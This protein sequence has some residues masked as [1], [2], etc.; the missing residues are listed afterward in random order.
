MN[1]PA[2]TGQENQDPN[3][4]IEKIKK[5][6]VADQHEEESSDNDYLTAVREELESK[7]SDKDFA[8]FV[9]KTIKRTVRQEDSLV[10]QIFYTGLSKDSANPLN[11]AVLAPTSEG[12]TYPVLE[13][14]QYFP[15]EE[16]WKIGSMSPKVIIRQSGIL[17]DNNNQPLAD[18][19]KELKRKIKEVDDKSDEKEDLE[20]Q[21]SQLYNEAKVLID[22]RGKLWVF[23]EAASCRDMGHFEANLIA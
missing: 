7:I 6:L 10:R 12:K 20:Q 15:K 13:S 11:L 1:E 19:I 14:L 4:N 16:I 18:R 5:R 2:N 9:I 23:L 21:L 8:E 3:G 22:L 17:V